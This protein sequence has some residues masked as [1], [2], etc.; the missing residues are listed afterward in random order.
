MKSKTIKDLAQNLTGFDKKEESSLKI[1]S[2][3]YSDSM[4]KVKSIIKV[5]NESLYGI[6]NKTLNGITLTDVCNVLKLA[7]DIIDNFDEDFQILD[8]IRECDFK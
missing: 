5:C 1:Q 4:F 2:Y 3:G 7:T 8:E 6:E